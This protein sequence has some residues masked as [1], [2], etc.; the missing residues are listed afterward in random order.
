M[1]SKSRFTALL[2]SVCI[3]LAGGTGCANRILGDNQ[4]REVDR[5]VPDG[6][7]AFDGAATSSAAQRQWDQFF[8]D[9]HVRA[10]IEEALDNNQELNIQLQEIIIAQAE[11]GAR[12]GEYL[13]FVNAGVGGGVEKVGDYS[14]QGAA[15]EA[16]GV[17]V[18]LPYLGFGL[19]ASW[20]ID[21]WS[22]LRNAAKA[23]NYRYLSSIEAR[24]FMVT[25]I[26]GEIA[27]SYYE[28]L[29]LDNQLQVLERYIAIQQDALEIVKLKKQAARATELAVQR[30]EAEVA[31]NQSMRY[32]L[33]QR[34]I[35]AENRIN[36]LVGRFPVHVERD[37]SNFL[38][39]EPPAVDA[40]IP[41]ELLDNRPDVRQADML[42]EAAELDVKSAKARFY[43]SLSIDAAVGYGSFNPAHLVDTPAS[44]IF[45]IAG[46]LVAP[47]LNRAAIKADY[48]SANARQIQA[49]FEYE[50][51]LLM[52]FTEVVN[53]LAMVQNLRNRY[54]Q[55]S[56]QVETLEAAI[57]T[58]SILYQTARADYM[59]VLLTRRDALEAEMEL[60][61][62]RKQQ[63][64]AMVGIY[65]AL[66][67]G[68]RSED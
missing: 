21:V 51:T 11:V 36:F 47:L 57:D 50:R 28:L 3:S 33:E 10:L 61:E 53:Y 35:E 39:T 16:N 56:K 34:R 4:P 2:V 23:A 17:P 12:K 60:I 67:G 26:I 19:S 25:Q 58:S 54:E 32:D 41:S 59:E 7:G 38:A 68:W 24:N 52:A 22:K 14:S 64:Q 62:T 63:M 49:V 18:P 45:N 27:D 29:A 43:P 8:T 66:G 65:R 44:L 5:S 37:A 1:T 30:F 20:E 13:P 6:W 46:N 48:R 55:L 15:D 9:P 31:K 40:G 42:L